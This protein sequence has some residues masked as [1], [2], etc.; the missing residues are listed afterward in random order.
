MPGI[1][2]YGE[3]EYCGGIGGVVYGVKYFGSD[4]GGGPFKD[5]FVGILNGSTSSY[6]SSSL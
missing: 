2:V 3:I 6:C 4:V 1:A 5:G